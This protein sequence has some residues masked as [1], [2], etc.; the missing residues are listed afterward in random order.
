MFCVPEGKCK[1]LSM[2]KEF[3]QKHW[4]YLL[5]FFIVCFCAS[6]ASAIRGGM[7]FSSPCRI[8]G[9]GNYYSSETNLLLAPS[10]LLEQL[11]TST[12]MFST[13]R[14]SASFFLIF[15]GVYQVRTADLTPW[16]D[17]TLENGVISRLR[18]TYITHKLVV[19]LSVFWWALIYFVLYK[20]VKTNKVLGW[21]LVAYLAIYLFFLILIFVKIYPMTGEENVTRYFFSLTKTPR[22]I[23]YIGP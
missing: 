8:D 6:D 12:E 18:W 20:T 13:Y 19:L 1:V 14:S 16:K 2:N 9:T 23:P 11:A 22:D 17:M 4:A 5:A 15:P 21:F 7:C 10:A 3:L